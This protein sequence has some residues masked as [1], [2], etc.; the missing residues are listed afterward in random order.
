MEKSLVLIK[1]DAVEKKLIG[2]I[3]ARFEK[4]GLDIVKLELLTLSSKK[5][6]EHYKEHEGKSFFEPLIEFI[7]SGALVAMVLEGER[8]ISIIRQ[9]CGKTDAGLA[10]PGTIRGD[11]SIYNNRNIVHASDS[12]ES[13]QREIKVFFG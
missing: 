13:A 2:E 6:R 12:I 8:C 4:R 10:E 11:Y 1:P 7:T 5:A 3:I 9:M